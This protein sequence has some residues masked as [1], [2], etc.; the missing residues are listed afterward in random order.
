MQALRKPVKR[1]QPTKA[2][3]AMNEHGVIVA[4][5]DTYREAGRGMRHLPDGV[6]GVSGLDPSIHVQGGLVSVVHDYL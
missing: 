4:E 2:V 6:Y 5:F 3:S 1:A